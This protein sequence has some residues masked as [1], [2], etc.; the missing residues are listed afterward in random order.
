M[1]LQPRDEA[2]LATV[3]RYRVLNA[4][5][6]QVLHFPGT[7]HNPNSKKT[8]CQGRL[9]KMYHHGYLARIA[10]P[11]VIPLGR[12]P[13]VYALDR[14]GA[15]R[16]A[17]LSGRDRAEIGWRPKNNQLGA[18]FLEHLLAVNQFRVVIELLAA[19]NGWSIV[20]WLDD[21]TLRT[22]DAAHALPYRQS[23]ARR[24]P[25]IPDGYFALQLPD[26]PNP[27]HFFL[28][29]DRGTETNRTWAHKIE[30]YTTYLRAGHSTRALGAQN[31]RVLC[32]VS[33][34][35]RLANLQRVTTTA[36][37]KNLC[38]FLT[39]DQVDIW[40]PTRVLDRIWQ[41]AGYEQLFALLPTQSSSGV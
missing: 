9:Q 5:Q 20:R 16:L 33:S 30:A 38:W 40:Q 15:D 18:L 6:I 2:V 4:H 23:G 10:Q 21:G 35:R 25:I 31:F 7:P 24:R 13:L 39:Q 3:H 37:G 27:F 36:N 41:V 28:E 11:Q 22:P 19:H 12:R 17:E 34:A 32:L 26:V 14:R 29:V 8:T 1:Q